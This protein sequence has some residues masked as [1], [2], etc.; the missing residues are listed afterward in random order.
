MPQYGVWLAEG[1][2]S[3]PAI[4]LDPDEPPPDPPDDPIHFVWRGT[5]D[6]RD[7]AVRTAQAEWARR[8]GPRAPGGR[9][10]A[11]EILPGD[12]GYEPELSP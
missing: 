6:S 11:Q 10:Y 3:G 12:A 1:V 8:Y 9:C 5:V 7:E 4:R 2:R